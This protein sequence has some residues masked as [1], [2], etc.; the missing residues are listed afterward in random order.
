MKY[1]F[2]NI[3]FLFTLLS[4]GQDEEVV[5]DFEPLG[6]KFEQA[7][8]V[9]LS[10]TEGATIYYTLD[11]S[12]PSSGASRYKKPIEVKTVNVIRAVAYKDGKRSE[13]VT[14][15]YFC[16]REYT[17]P[18]VSI[19]TNPGNLWDYSTGIYVK[20]CCADTIEPYVGANFWRD[21]E[22]HANI[23]MYE[24]DGEL[25]F[26]QGV[27]INLFGGFS[28]MLPQKSLAVFAR[29]K[30]GEKR[31][32]YPIFP[33]RDFKK[34]KSFIIRNSG[35][36]FRRTHFRDAFMT[37][38][39]ASTGVAIQAYRPAIVFLNGEYW[40]IQNLREKISEHYLKSNFG[41]DKDN[42][43][44]LRHN[45]VKRHGF[46]ANYKKLLRFLRTQDMSID[47][48]VAELRTFMDVEDYLRYN[49]AETYSDNR[50]AGGNIRYW[51]ERNDSA[52]WRWVLYD[53]DLGLGNNAY[54]GYKRNTVKKFTSA[55]YEAWPDPA[56]STFIIRKLLENENVKNQYINTF[57]D[58]LNTVYSSETALALIDE[59]HGNLAA[60]MPYHVDKWKTTIK[61]WNFHVDVV[62]EFVRERPAYLRKFIIE[63]FELKGLI[64]VTIKY[65]GDEVA[66]VT[67]NSLKIKEDFV[68]IYFQDVPVTITV[69]PKHDYN[70]IGWEGR[71][72]KTPSIT[73]NSSSDILLEPLFEPKERSVLKDS[74]IFNEIT[75][76]QAEGD[77]SQDWIELYNHSGSSVDLSGW[78]WTKSSF[79]KGFVLPE[80]TLIAANDYLI[81]ARNK[82]NYGA[83]YNTDTVAVIGD[84]E[85]GL[86]K[87]GEHIKLYDQEGLIVD[88]LTYSFDDWDTT[89]TFNLVHPDS[90]SDV[91]ANW[92]IEQPNPGDISRAYKAYLKHEADKKYWTKIYYIGGGSFFF[93]LVVGLLLRR[94]FKKRKLKA[95]GLKEEE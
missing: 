6:G 38:L 79:K 78:K 45:G 43:D 24:T 42:V 82:A 59:M 53:L 25:C 19:A 30:Y 7:I 77:T 13:T 62:R 39:A 86:S 44:I 83:Y 91:F 29:E 18:I 76:Y 41:V 46:S 1:L 89:A 75:V 63:K 34:Y 47:S 52:K 12:R 71:D 8:T 36:D 72:E 17:L 69:E 68:G 32:K 2:S 15:S 20:G 93:I 66:K 40:G 65:P 31:I 9:T 80:N 90:A 67:F 5:I 84:F 64:D 85:F 11:G 10:A 16:D 33:E 87:K 81:L 48:T 70:F 14:Q 54:T 4:F 35:G 95:A 51:R 37:Q 74:I 94:S 55:N 56:W 26:N 58:H 27:G 22:K 49:I 3:L 60:E 61:N 50:D 88:S 92:N 23:E 28:R 57:A 21:W 73:V